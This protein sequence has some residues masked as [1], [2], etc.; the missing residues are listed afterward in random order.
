LTNRE[1]TDTERFPP[2]WSAG[3]N[4]YRCGW[5]LDFQPRRA[6]LRGAR[7][8][9]VETGHLVIVEQHQH[10]QISRKEAAPD[11]PMP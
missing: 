11:A 6:T 1:R 4:D 8:H 3:C 5:N 7:K 9:A 2:T 10:W